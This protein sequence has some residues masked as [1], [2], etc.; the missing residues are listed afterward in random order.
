MGLIRLTGDPA[1]TA[2]RRAAWLMTFNRVGEP[3]SPSN[4]K[5]GKMNTD[6]HMETQH[7]LSLASDEIERLRR[8]NE[9]LRAK[10]DVMELFGLTLRTRPDYGSQGVC[11]DIVWRMKKLHNEIESQRIARAT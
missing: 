11:E 3:L 7:C 1:I 4:L 9:I 2:I 5:Q 10:V 8:D 6:L